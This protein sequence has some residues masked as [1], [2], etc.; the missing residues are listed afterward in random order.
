MPGMPSIPGK[1]S[2]ATS[3]LP[4]AQS[5][6]TRATPASGAPSAKRPRTVP[7]LPN[8]PI[9]GGLGTVPAWGRPDLVIHAPGGVVATT[10][11]HFVMSAGNTTTLVASQD[12]NLQSQRHTAIA[13]KSG[14]SLFTYGKATN[15]DKPNTETGM[16]FHAASGNVSVQ[17]Q[18]NTLAL[19]AD[20]AINVSSVTNAITMGAP[21]H[22]LLTAGGSAIRIQGGSITLTTSGPANFK[23]AMKELAGAGS[24][25]VSLEMKKAGPLKTC[26]FRAGGAANGGDA[27]V[28][29]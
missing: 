7:A 2:A 12:I 23:A 27:L 20:K 8:I 22:I 4:V 5:A 3:S 29:L 15:P 19:T 21:K 28:P 6:S 14:I 26:E 16:Q 9:A 10:P 11:A 17:A 1:P 18:A 13:V 25:S 24:A